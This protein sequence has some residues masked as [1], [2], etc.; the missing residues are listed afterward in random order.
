MRTISQSTDLKNGWWTMSTK[1]VSLLQ[2]RRS[3]GFLFKKPFKTDEALTER[4]RG[5]R[6]VFSKMTEKKKGIDMKSIIPS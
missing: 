6:I 3:A 5:M 4:D 1:P 2:P